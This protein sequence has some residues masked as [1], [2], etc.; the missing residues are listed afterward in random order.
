MRRARARVSSAQS[1]VPLSCCLS[2]DSSRSAASRESRR[3]A[4]GR[5]L[6]NDPAASTETRGPLHFADEGGLLV[7]Y[8]HAAKPEEAAFLRSVGGVFRYVGQHL[9]IGIGLGR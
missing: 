7:T 8:A 9:A 3:Y 4:T 2:G 1:S 5:A 6:A